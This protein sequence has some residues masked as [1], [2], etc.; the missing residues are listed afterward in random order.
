V[1]VQVTGEELTIFEM[2][3]GA[4]I[5]LHTV[6]NGRRQIT[7]QTG[8]LKGIMGGGYNSAEDTSAQKGIRSGELERPLSQYEEAALL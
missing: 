5:A 8:H 6:K 1:R 4:V 7:I 2:P 3:S